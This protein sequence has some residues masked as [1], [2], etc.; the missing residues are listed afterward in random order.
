MR[1]NID[2][3]W[4][5]V[6][7]GSVDRFRCVQYRFES[8]DDWRTKDWKGFK[9]AIG[10]NRGIIPQTDRGITKHLTH[11]NLC[12]VQNAPSNCSSRALRCYALPAVFSISKS[13]N[14][15]CFRLYPRYLIVSVKEVN[16]QKM[17]NKDE[18]HWYCHYNRALVYVL[19][20]ICWQHTL[21]A[22]A[23][24]LCVV[25]Y[26]KAYRTERKSIERQIQGIG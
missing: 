21:T 8:Y 10:P 14:T 6:V 22:G 25:G 16:G 4:R 12:P 11:D 2:A 7:S 3:K 15:S 13:C 26:N 17:R 24:R 23:Y 18:D 5:W 1:H 9:E 19:A 20:E